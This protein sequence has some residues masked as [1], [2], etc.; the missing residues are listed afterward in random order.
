[1]EWGLLGPGAGQ[2]QPWGW[3]PHSQV[4]P[5]VSWNP[6]GSAQESTFQPVPTDGWQGSAPCHNPLLPHCVIPIGERCGRGP[7]VDP[8]YWTGQSHPLKLC[9]LAGPWRGWVLGANGCHS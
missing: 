6:G 3:S 4:Y 5:A 7:L 1:M 9:P 8:D 2:S